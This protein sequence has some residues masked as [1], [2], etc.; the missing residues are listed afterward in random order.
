MVVPSMILQPLVEN[1][2]RHGIAPKIEGGAITLRANRRNGR[3]TVEVIDD[4]VG[5]SGQRQPE[6][7][8]GGI[9]ISNVR[10]RLKVVYGQD[11]LMKI[12]SQPGKGTAIRIEIPELATRLPAA[13]GEPA[14]VST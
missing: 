7:Y 8:G 6:V 12:D 10:E 3:L 13:A 14:S 11:F 1:A 9:G 5:I 2:L 4:G